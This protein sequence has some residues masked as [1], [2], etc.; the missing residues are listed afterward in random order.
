MKIYIQHYNLNNIAFLDEY[1]YNEKTHIDIYSNEG[2]FIVD[3]I[4]I[5]KLKITDKDVYKIENYGVNF[6]G[7][8]NKHTL[9]IDESVIEKETVFQI[10]PDHIAIKLTTFTYKM[11]QKSN[12]SLVIEGT[13]NKPVNNNDRYDGFEL[14]DFYFISSSNLTEIKD[15][16][17]VFLSLLN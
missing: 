17:C 4:Q 14:T 3:N 10:P 16:L 7:S 2:I 9:L 15:N 1:L 6:S 8:N 12:V 13:Y 5:F 11:Y